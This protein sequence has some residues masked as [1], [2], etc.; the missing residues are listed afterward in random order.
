MHYVYTGPL[1]VLFLILMYDL[2][3]NELGYWT[4][5]K[6]MIVGF[7]FLI[8]ELIKEYYPSWVIL[9]AICCMALA[10]WLVTSNSFRKK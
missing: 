8:I 7:I 6:L 2:K 3:R 1:L 5:I 4:I 10:P 9:A